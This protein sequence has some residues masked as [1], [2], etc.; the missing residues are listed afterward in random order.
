MEAFFIYLLKSMGISLLFLG[1]YWLFLRK[2][3]FFAQNRWFLQTGLILALFLPFLHFTKTVWLEAEL[4]GRA[5]PHTLDME[6]SAAAASLDLYDY[7]FLVYATGILFLTTRLLLQLFS[8]R[9]L[10]SQGRT[11]REGNVHFVETDRDLT[12]FSFFNYVVYHPKNHSKR[13]LDVILAHERLHVEQWHS[14]DILLTHILVVLQWFNPFI[15]QYRST[16]QQNLEFIADAHTVILDCQD[17]KQYQYLLLRSGTES[18]HPSLVNPFF[19]SLI[20]KRIVMMNQKQSHSKNL[21]KYSFIL[22]LLLLFILVF[23]VRTEAKIRT[24]GAAIATDLAPRHDAKVYAISKTMTDVELDV[25]SEE[26]KKEKGRLTVKGLKRNRAGII[27]SI[28]IGYKSEN[29]FVSSSYNGKEGIATIHFGVNEEGGPFIT[30]IEHQVDHLIKGNGPHENKGSEVTLHP[31]N[32]V[33]HLHSDSGSIQL[34]FDE[35]VPLVILDGREMPAS[36]M[37]SLEMDGIESMDVSKGEGA[38]KKYGKKARN[39]VVEITS[40]KRKDGVS[41]K[42]REIAGDPDPLYFLDGKEIT[43]EQMEAIDP[44]TIASVSVLKNGEAIKKY[45]KK[46]KNGVIEITSKKNQ[47]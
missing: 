4:T 37:D 21:I 47:N 42:I 32:V 31:S 29:G 16:V 44:E 8:L 1:C 46:G 9:K 18:K 26:I 15:W 19:N 22:P 43:K 36:I 27:V 33:G 20:K 45:G 35:K 10:I 24:S 41:L 39:G 11:T 40:K 28:E 25:L 23:H 38:L 5:V 7:L 34:D 30:S 17:K 12:P 6:Q 2:E 14:L 13:E 3:T